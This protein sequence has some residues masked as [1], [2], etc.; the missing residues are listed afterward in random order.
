[1]HSSVAFS[2]LIAAG[3][4]AQSTMIL[5]NPYAPPMSTVTVKGTNPTATTVE[6]NCP[7][8][9]NSKRDLL[10]EKCMPYIATQGP[11]TWE[12]HVSHPTSGQYTMDASCKFGEGGYAKANATCTVFA[13]GKLNGALTGRTETNT[14]QP[15]WWDSGAFLID[16]KQ[17]VTLVQGA[18][19]TGSGAASNV[20][21][22]PSAGA[23]ASRSG[24]APSGTASA[25]PSS[26]LA[27]SMALPTGGTIAFVGGAA[28]VL[29][30][31]LA[32]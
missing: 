7:A 23:S 11:S 2:L 8:P 3:A 13:D 5:L 29:A 15:S 14:L 24:P 17:T 21:N 27:G 22:A 12:M 26:G 30:A 10:D 16:S 4:S 1:M 6:N 32:L 19:A 20:T 31:A 25:P 28:G 18:Q 9:T